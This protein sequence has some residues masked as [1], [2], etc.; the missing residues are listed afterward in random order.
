MPTRS[1]RLAMETAAVVA[2][3]LGTVAASAST[4]PFLLLPLL[5]IV[6]TGRDPV[7]YGLCARVRPPSVPAHAVIGLGASA[8]ALVWVELGA[9]LAP[10]WPS[11]WQR[12]LWVQFVLVA[13][14]EEVFFRGY[15]QTNLDRI[16]G[17][18]RS[19]G[20]APVG[21]GWPLQAVVFAFAHLLGS[22]AFRWDVLAFGLL[23]GWLRARSGSIAA[24]VA[25]HGAGNAIVAVASP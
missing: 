1:D 9:G 3:T 20:G 2:L 8:A 24:G 10:R 19:V 12:I 16:F 17:T 4:A 5:A 6:T 11:D 14:P 15:L 23:A 7:G 21:L 22:P 13:L 18:P 25:Y